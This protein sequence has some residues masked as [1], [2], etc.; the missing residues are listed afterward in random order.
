M[1]LADAAREDVMTMDDPLLLTVDEAAA[2]LRISR[3]A[4]YM[5]I[6]QHRLPHVRMGRTIRIPAARLREWID[7]EAGTPL[8]PMVVSWSPASDGVRSSRRADA[9]P[10]PIR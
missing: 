2:L 4:T 8:D 5:L 10:R 1:S 6:R 7:R 9:P 3:N